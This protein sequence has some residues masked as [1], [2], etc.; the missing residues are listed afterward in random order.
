MILVVFA[1]F[2]ANTFAQQTVKERIQRQKDACYL[3]ALNKGYVAWD[4]YMDTVRS[5]NFQP[6]LEENREYYIYFIID[7]AYVGGELEILTRMDKINGRPGGTIKVDKNIVQ[8]DLN[9]PT[10]GKHYIR[11]TLPDGKVITEPIYVCVL[12]FAK[13]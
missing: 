1:L 9:T 10:N 7:P 12:I 11:Y 8:S 3:E 5:L 2:T 4:E 6:Y 13:E